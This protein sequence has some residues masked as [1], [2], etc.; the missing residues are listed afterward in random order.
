MKATFFLNG[1]MASVSLF[2]KFDVIKNILT[3]W[4]N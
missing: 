4:I 3:D 2:I 1:I